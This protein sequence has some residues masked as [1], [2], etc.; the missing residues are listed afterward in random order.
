MSMAATRNK[1][2]KATRILRTL[3]KIISK[4]EVFTKIVTGFKS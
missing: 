1:V 3:Y 2:K 4:T